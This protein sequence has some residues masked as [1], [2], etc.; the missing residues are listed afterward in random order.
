MFLNN[1][2][3]GLGYYMVG[4]ST[5]PPKN[6]SGA[7]QTT[8]NYTNNWTCFTATL[9]YGYNPRLSNP[10]TS[11]NGYGGVI[12]G[13]GTTEPTPED[14]ALSGDM[15]TDISVSASKIEGLLGEDGATVS[16]RY[17]ITNNAS[18]DIVVGEIGLIAAP[19]N[20]TST[21]T[22]CLLD[23]TVLDTPVTISAGGVG[24]VTYTITM[25]YPTE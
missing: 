4:D 9:N 17:T 19:S 10:L 3:K 21:S 20:S 23:R 13:T 16:Y 22:K 25:D 2:F 7:A 18:S 15:L 8:L 5:N 24:Q 14:Y 6:L 1:F 11:L 12:F